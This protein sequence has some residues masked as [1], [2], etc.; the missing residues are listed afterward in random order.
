MIILEGQP[1]RILHRGILK[2][3][4]NE[5]TQDFKNLG[6]SYY[7][8]SDNMWVAFKFDELPETRSFNTYLESMRW[9]QS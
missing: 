4:S 5:F 3:D 9:L 1:A 8:H 6:G 7:D 2:M